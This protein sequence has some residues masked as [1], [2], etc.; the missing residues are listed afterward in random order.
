MLA[1]L[2][3]YLSENDLNTSVSNYL[4]NELHI[5]KYTSGEGGAGLIKQLKQLY[6]KFIRKMLNEFRGMLQ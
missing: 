3:E 6:D 2:C 1:R 4:T 5:E